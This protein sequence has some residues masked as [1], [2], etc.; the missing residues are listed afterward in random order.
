MLMK[1][2][3]ESTLTSKEQLTVP[4]VVRQLL[5][6]HAG[7]SLVWSLDEQGRLVV[8]G[9]R[10]NSL[11]DIRAAVAAAGPMHTPKGVTVADMNSGIA[12]AMR[13]KHGRG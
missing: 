5:D 3:A 13:R 12:A 2:L 11:A 6:V 1:I 4:R 9:G 8:S 10:P 7:D